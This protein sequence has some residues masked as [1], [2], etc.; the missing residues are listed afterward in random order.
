M[1]NTPPNAAPL[2]L[3][4]DAAAIKRAADLLRRGGLVAFPTET[5]YGL[6]ADALNA[7]AVQRIFAAKGR[8]ATN[9]LIVHAVDT[10]AARE[11]VDNWPA[12][13]QRLA[14]H[15]WPG[16]LTLV[17]NRN[18]RVP[19][20]T[21]AGGPTV[22]L[23]V[24][25]HA[26]A[27]ALLRAA[28]TPIAAPSANRSTRVSPT[29]AEH[30][31]AGLGE[32]VDLILDGGATTGGIEST[33]LDLT[34]APPRVLRLGLVTPDALSAAIG[35]PVA[36]AV[37]HAASNHAA[38]PRSPGQSARHYAPH[39]RLVVAPRGGETETRRAMT[40]GER[41]GWL[42]LQRGAPT[43]VDAAVVALDMPH[44]ADDYAARLYAA[45]H[46]LDAA[47]VS[48]IIVDEPPRAPEWA[49]IHDRLRRAATADETDPS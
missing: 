33:V 10:D 36:V 38:R 18:D 14:G 32:R 3:A 6:G 35:E 22:A 21:T 2:V 25:A 48:V 34:T 44:A 27:R 17:L 12:I 43:P 49:A 40:R 39:A 20:I 45:L 26:V 5:V 37:R 23:R 16:P 31:R 41:V 4:A 46:E 11:L 8:P 9:P 24:P 30:V 7:A 15:F 28:N 19:A 13:A 29:T 47:G 1:S 42:R